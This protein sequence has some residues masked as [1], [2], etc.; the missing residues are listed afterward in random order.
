[1]IRAR[2]SASS[3]S[4]C[5]LQRGPR[6]EE[7]TMLD[8]DR[9]RFIGTA[10]MSAAGIAVASLHPAGAAQPAADDVP[11]KPAGVKQGAMFD[12]RFPE[13]YETAL[14]A[15]L[16]V[17]T[18]YFAALAR[19]DLRAMAKS[20]HYP[21]AIYEGVEALV[22]DSEAAMLA[23]PPPS[24]NVSGTLPPGLKGHGGLTIRKG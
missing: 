24:M 8:S 12:C 2:K 22:V 15:A 21:F 5:R 1:M 11:A 7:M 17:V 14:P 6:A 3:G 20:F 4:R 16:K 19:R 18:D 13:A 23:N 9:R 10:M